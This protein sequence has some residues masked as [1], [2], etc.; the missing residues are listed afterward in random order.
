[1]K[2]LHVT[3]EFGDIIQKLTELILASLH[4]LLERFQFVF[5]S[6]HSLKVVDVV[7]DPAVELVLDIL[8][9]RCDCSLFFSY[10]FWLSKNLDL[11]GS[12]LLFPLPLFYNGFYGDTN[13]NVERV[14]IK[15][16][17]R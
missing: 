8:L 16:R 17:R 4:L 12:N 7:G 10:I 2:V 6:K 13:A 1:M 15:V 5:W 11:L 3:D 14:R 9:N